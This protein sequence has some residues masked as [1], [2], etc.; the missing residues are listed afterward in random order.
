MQHKLNAD[1]VGFSK[2]FYR[3]YPKQKK[4]IEDHWD[5]IF[6]EVEVNINIKAYIRREGFIT[7]PGAMPEKEVKEK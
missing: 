5:E 7:K 6:P 2:E 3:K 4:T 1:I